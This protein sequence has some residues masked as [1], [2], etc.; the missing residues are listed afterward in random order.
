QQ[1]SYNG[2]LNVIPPSRFSNVAKNIIAFP[3]FPKPNQLGTDA[4]GTLN[5]YFVQSKSGGSNDQYTIRAEQNLSSKQTAFER[6]THWHSAN[7]PTDPIGNGIIAGD[8]GSP[9]NFTTQQ[10]VVGDTF[11]FNPTSV[12]D[13]HLS[14]LRWN[15]YR[16]P[17]HRGYDSTQLGF[18]SYMG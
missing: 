18:P 2:K 16:D 1:F 3:Y 7:F 11:I 12:A 15:Y 13:I 9:E 10:L 8:P 14:Y 6:Y 17:V 4:A 5:N